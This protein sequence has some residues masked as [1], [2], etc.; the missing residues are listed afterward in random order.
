MNYCSFTL[1]STCRASKNDHFRQ[2][3][4]TDER[5]EERRPD[6]KETLHQ[7]LH[8]NIGSINVAGNVQTNSGLRIYYCSHCSYN[9]TVKCNMARHVQIHTGE[10]PFACPYCPYR[11]HEKAKI[12]RHMRTHQ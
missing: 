2:V 4:V 12:K 1:T 3:W 10:K 7:E 9:T 11:S 8:V 5:P 6:P